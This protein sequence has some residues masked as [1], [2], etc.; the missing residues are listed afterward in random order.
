MSIDLVDGDNML[1]LHDFPRIGQTISSTSK[2]TKSD[3]SKD[4]FDHL[5]ALNFP[6]DVVNRL[7]DQHDFSSAK[8]KIVAAQPGTHKDDSFGLLRLGKLVKAVSSPSNPILECITGSTGQWGEEWISTAVPHLLNRKAPM[9]DA[10][11][12]FRTVFPTM[13]AVRATHFENPEVSPCLL[14][15]LLTHPAGTG[16]VF[17]P[18][19]PLQIHDCPRLAQEMLPS[20][21][22][23][24]WC[25][26]FLPS[27]DALRPGRLQDI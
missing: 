24:K 22:I 4:F 26:L 20:L 3:F 2:K 19:Q 25:R 13:K 16:N 9:D 18:W 17:Q 14:L 8:A 27:E 6:A 12:L 1:Y 15:A 23:D 10:E 5:L 21:Q 11:K 7:H